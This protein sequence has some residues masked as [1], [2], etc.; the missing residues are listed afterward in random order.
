MWSHQMKTYGRLKQSLSANTT[1]QPHDLRLLHADCECILT[2]VRD[3]IIDSKLSMIDLSLAY[4][5][6]QVQNIPIW[7]EREH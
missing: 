7:T 3:R 6:C 5:K 2:K 4:F 1:M